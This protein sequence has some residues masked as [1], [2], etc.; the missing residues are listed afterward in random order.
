M[1]RW[2]D[3]GRERKRPDKCGP[4]TNGSNNSR[5]RVTAVAAV[6]VEGTGSGSGRLKTKRT[7]P[8]R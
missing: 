4:V 2:R 1:E 6:T 7:K 3:G 5:E 8:R